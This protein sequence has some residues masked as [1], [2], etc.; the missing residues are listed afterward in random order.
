[1]KTKELTGGLLEYWVAMAEWRVG[2]LPAAPRLERDL[3]VITDE[4]GF[5]DS[6]TFTP[7]SSWEHGGP[8]I[9]RERI[10]FSDLSDLETEGDIRATITR[11][12]RVVDVEGPTHLIAAMRAYVLHEFGEDVPDQPQA[13]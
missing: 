7:A 11:L 2:N 1:M 3:V 6:W 8:I 5:Q 12:P 13:S 9:G 4:E 10:M